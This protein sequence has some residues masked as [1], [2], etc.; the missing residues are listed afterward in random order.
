MTCEARNEGHIEIIQE[1]IASTCQSHQVAV[2]W[3]GGA[4]TAWVN[5]DY[6]TGALMSFSSKQLL[7]PFFYLIKV[8]HSQQIQ[9]QVAVDRWQRENIASGRMCH[10]KGHFWYRGCSHRLSLRLAAHYA[11][12][13]RGV[14]MLHYFIFCPLQNN[15]PQFCSASVFLYWVSLTPE[16]KKQMLS[17]LCHTQ[18]LI[19]NPTLKK[20]LHLWHICLLSNT[21]LMNSKFDV[22]VQSQGSRSHCCVIQSNEKHLDRNWELNAD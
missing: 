11:L 9:P 22:A 1:G 7:P 8:L 13:G 10:V 15:I 19:L 2:R 3:R 17:R 16:D 12:T 20:K 18:L 21:K 4:E 6:V 14:I 5:K